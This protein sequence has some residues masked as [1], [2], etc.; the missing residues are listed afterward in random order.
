MLADVQNQA[1]LDLR[2]GANFI[3]VSDGAL[4]DTTYLRHNFLEKV[5]YLLLGARFVTDVHAA[6]V[7]RHGKGV[8]LCGESGAGKSTLSYGCARTGW[9]F[10]SDDTCYLINAAR[11]PRVIGH[12]HRVRFRPSA[13]ELFPELQGRTVVE[14]MEGKPSIEVPIRELPVADTATEANVCAIVYL[15]R[16]QT[17]NAQLFRLPRGS[18]TARMS[19]DLYSAG[20][21]RTKHEKSL[22]QFANT[23]VFELH[24]CGLDD[25]LQYLNRLVDGL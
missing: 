12:A 21:I 19:Q 20:D 16:D 17:T 4:T 7:S 24:Y 9:T 25:A 13:A 5:T 2:T 18:A 3:W 22:E 14:R 23:P 10:T 6:C 11:T 15:R 8:L 1:V